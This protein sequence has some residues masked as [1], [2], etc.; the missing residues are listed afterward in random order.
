MKLLITGG[1][2]TPAL[3]CLDEVLNNKSVEVIFVG[4][5]YNSDRENTLTFEYSEVTSYGVLFVHLLAGRLTHFLSL[6]N[7]VGI[8]LIPVG[9][10]HAF[11][12]LTKHKPDIILSFGGYIALPIC[13]VA[14]LIG[15]PVY[16]HE[17][18]VQPGMTNR[19]LAVL[20]K[21]VFVSFPETKQYFPKEKV[22]LTGNPVRDVVY[23][24]INKPFITDRSRK[25][26]YITG[27]SLGSH[28]INDHIK[29]ILPKLLEKYTVIHQTGNVREYHDYEDLMKLRSSFPSQLRER[30]FLRQHLTGTEIGFVYFHTDLVISR[31]GAN[32][33]S[34]L[35]TLQKP[36]LLIP[37]PWSAY[38]EQS[39]QAQILK[40]NGV[41]E[42]FNQYDESSQLLAL[43]EKMMNNIDQYKQNYNKLSSYIY[44]DAAK[45][46]IS[47]ITHNT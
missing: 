35:I 22:L 7:L 28:S 17:Q 13:C 47:E 8:V 4:R 46:I 31:A 21:K 6:K 19:V 37:L 12:I 34:E 30:Y 26:I 14:Y 16:T 32:T 24:V 1:H 42:I 39:R 11:L 20:A 18:T 33:F 5:K 10:L 25:I 29:N 2:S 38:N 9:F 3:A 36:A 40:E 45:K 41:A 27:G 43:A 15:I 44:P 23:K